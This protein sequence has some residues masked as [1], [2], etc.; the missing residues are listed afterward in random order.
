MDVNIGV[1]TLS[2]YM[3][4]CPWSV[5]LTLISDTLVSWETQ[6]YV[7]RQDIFEQKAFDHYLLVYSISWT[8]YVK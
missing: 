8:K 1:Y 3:C 5:L 2:R 4:T 6:E 7:H